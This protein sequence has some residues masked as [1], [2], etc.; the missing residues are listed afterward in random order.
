MRKVSVV[1]ERFALGPTD[2]LSPAE[3]ARV[4]PGASTLAVR[5]W[6]AD[7]KLSGAIQLPS[8]RWQIPWSAVVGILGFDPREGESAAVAGGDG[9]V[10]SGE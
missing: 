9:V 10:A 1:T 5:R 2:Y 3:A 8:G 6:A 7:G 4:I